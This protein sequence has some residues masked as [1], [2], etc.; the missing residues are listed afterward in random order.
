[1]VD[2]AGTTKFTYDA[3]GLLN[4]E[5][6]PWASDTVTYTYNNRLRASL[7]LQQ[8]TGS[9]TNGF[10]YDAAHR[11]SKVSSPAGTFTKNYLGASRLIQKLALPNT[12]YITNTYDNVARLTG[13]Y[14]DHSRP[15][16]FE[17]MGWN[18]LFAP[19]TRQG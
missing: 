11:L 14:L 17:E 13:T 2:G 16:E 18:F 7:S 8:P 6:G 5:D 15:R 3:G 12:S 9:W 1:M 4:T 10:T 19:A